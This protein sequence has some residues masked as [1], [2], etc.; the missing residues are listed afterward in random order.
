[1]KAF[2]SHSIIL[3][4]LA[5]FSMTSPAQEVSYTTRSG[6]TIG[7]G[8]GGSYQTSDIKN[9]TGAGFDF[10]LGSYL[11]KKNTALF[12]L[13]W[14][15]RFLAG[16]N[17][18]HDHRINTDNTYSNI[19][20]RHF[21]YDLEAGLTLNRLMEQTGIVLT[22]FAGAGI[23]HGITHTDLYDSSG[24]LYDYSVINP[25]RPR[26]EIK[27]DLLALSDNDYET[28]L[29]NKAALMPTAGIFLGYRFSRSFSLG[30]IHKINF[31][32]TEYNG[33]FGIDTDNK[34]MAGSG[35]DMHHYTSLGFRWILGRGSSAST[36]QRNT[37]YM[38]TA[39]ETERAVIVNRPAKVILDTSKAPGVDI[40]IPYKDIYSTSDR[41]INV[42]ARLSRVDYKEDIEVMYD[43]DCPAF[44]FDPQ[45]GRVDL[46][47]F[48]AK[49][50][51]LLTITGTNDSGSATDSL[52]LI[53]AGPVKKVKEQGRT[54]PV[55]IT[56]PVRANENTSTSRITRIS[57]VR[58]ENKTRVISREIRNEQL[59]VAQQEKA[60]PPVL[61]FINPVNPVTVYN[62]VFPLKVQTINIA[63]WNDVDVN[64][65]RVNNSNFSF[66]RDGVVNLNVA[67][68]EGV[69]TIEIS[70]KNSAGRVTEKTIIT[71]TKPVQ[72]QQREQRN[73]QQEQQEQQQEQQ[74][75][76]ATGIRIN[77]GNSAWQFCLITPHRSY[78]R[79]NLKNSDF[80][81]S[82]S[83]SSLY[84]MPTAGGGIATVNGR[85]YNVRS[86]RYYLFTGKLS[87]TVSTKN[88]GSMGHWSVII[89]ADRAPT[90][91][92][93]NKRPESPCDNGSGR[94]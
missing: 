50:T 53:F 36:V 88:P 92:N 11:Y 37:Q 62:N 57:D 55:N 27:A 44:E 31:S 67:L 65:N 63:S 66:T 14:K 87:V 48:M 28:A 83:A 30:I 64:V 3:F 12:A 49:D 18:A 90:S 93:G 89:T 41:S 34:V 5:S 6:L 60:R 43:Y 21:N 81:Y 91:G 2:C 32:L 47:V 9:S 71:Y 20:L 40:T 58:T 52:L 26:S 10:H 84:I 72:V 15:F 39:R 13:D 54:V 23:T 19:K 86:G 25:S 45:S 73:Q 85:P 56:N 75:E 82:G 59:A 1:M 79:D 42:T 29:V 24:N 76:R 38:S 22:G 74:Q 94:D 69:N 68:R 17:R 33:A 77:P 8:L 7:F 78:N 35:I 61:S 70:G 16:E 51:S 4:F 46:S 80:S